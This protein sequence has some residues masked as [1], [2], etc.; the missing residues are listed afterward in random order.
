MKRV[1]DVEQGHHDIGAGGVMK[2]QRA[3]T[4]ALACLAVVV[5]AATA[6]VA[7]GVGAQAA[8]RAKPNIVWLEQGADNP[9]WDAQHKAAAE[10]GRRLGFTFKAVSGNKNPSDQAYVM[11][12]LVDQGV[13]VIML[14]AIDP[15]AMAPGARLREAEGREGPEP[16]RRRAKAT[17]S[18]TF[19]EIRTGRVAAKYA[20]SC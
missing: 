4:Q 10:A 8:S 19:D 6:A 1:N 11:Q 3:D 7:S 12:Q 2:R 13:D 17:A 5:I 9:Y 14:N 18:V 20:A 15:K 16:V